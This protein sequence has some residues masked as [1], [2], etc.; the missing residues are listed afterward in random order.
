MSAQIGVVVL[1]PDGAE[2]AGSLTPGPAWST[3]KVPLAIAAL[4]ADPSL[5]P[6][7]SAAI[8]VSDNAAAQQLWESLGGGAAA[9]EAVEVVLRESGDYQ[10]QVNEQAT[11]PEFSV[12]G[13]TTWALADQA[14]FA[15]HLS[16]SSG[17][18]E[19]EVRGYMGQVSP[20]DSYGIGLLPDSHF[21][22]GWGPDP[23]GAYLTRQFGFSGDTAIAVATV[24][25]D[26]SYMTG[27]QVLSALVTQIAL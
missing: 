23:S 8:T 14:A 13:Q 9:A 2:S 10:T 4:R 25:A 7:A 21:K 12:F 20:Q 27:Q 24:P 18:A 19:A 5:S 17:G 22:G 16:S 11:R 6:Q 15:R 26:G 1:R 3:I